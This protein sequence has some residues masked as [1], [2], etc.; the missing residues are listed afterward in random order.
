M[1]ILLNSLMIE[2]CEKA[3]SLLKYNPVINAKSLQLS[4]YPEDK[5]GN[6]TSVYKYLIEY[7]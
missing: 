1:E 5:L 3:F 4:Y 6:E 7:F 2:E